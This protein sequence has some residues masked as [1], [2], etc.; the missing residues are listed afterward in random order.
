MSRKFVVI[1]MLLATMVA[2]A[3]VHAGSG[4][5]H[6][7][8]PPPGG[9]MEPGQGIDR[10]AKVLKLT[11]AQQTQIKALLDAEKE[12]MK[13]VFES[14]HEKR[15]QLRKLSEATSFDEAAVRTIATAIAQQEIELMI[16]RTGTQSKINAL[17]TAD[18]R[19]LLKNLR[20]D[21]DRR[22]P[23]HDAGEQ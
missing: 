7:N 18:Q 23:P 6:V 11:D 16:S 3:S 15:D 5:G 20:P 19:E 17:L 10:M 9:M 22:P 12:R 8:G 4:K 14:V 21:M 1:G 13:P 2:A